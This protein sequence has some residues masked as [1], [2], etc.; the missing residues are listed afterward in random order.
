MGESNNAACTAT[1][2]TACIAEAAPIRPVPRWLPNIMPPRLQPFVPHPPHL[3]HD[4][5]PNRQVAAHIPTPAPIA[6][7][8][9]RPRLSSQRFKFARPPSRLTPCAQS[10]LLFF[11]GTCSQLHTGA[12]GPDRAAPKDTPVCGKIFFRLLATSYLPNY[13]SCRHR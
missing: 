4:Y 10:P 11:A 9:T 7:H 8:P 5:R 6:V 13:D 12:H 2:T 1:T 3:S